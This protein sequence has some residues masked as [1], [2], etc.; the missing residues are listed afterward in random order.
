MTAFA[1]R[2]LSLPRGCSTNRHSNRAAFVTCDIIKRNKFRRNLHRLLTP[3]RRCGFKQYV[4]PFRSRTRAVFLWLIEWT[5]LGLRLESTTDSVC[6]IDFLDSESWFPSCHAKSALGHLKSSLMADF[7]HS[8][9]W[10]SKFQI[11]RRLLSYF[12]VCPH[13]LK[14]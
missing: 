4:D 13:G 12:T 3:S 2:P 7:T 6:P 9:L 14:V 8:R 11:H 5:G 10:Q 1:Q